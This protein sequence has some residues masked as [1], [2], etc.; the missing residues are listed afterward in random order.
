M[1]IKSKPGKEQT[2]ERVLRSRLLRDIR[3]LFMI[4]NDQLSRWLEEG[5]SRHNCFA[6]FFLLCFYHSCAPHMAINRCWLCLLSKAGIP[7]HHSSLTSYWAAE[8][9]ICCLCWA[10]GT[11]C[12]QVAVN[13]AIKESPGIWRT[14]MRLMCFDHSVSSGRLFLWSWCWNVA[15]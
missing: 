3:L 8:T 12:W 11:H 6:L 14:M 13:L 5:A 9:G 10:G 2:D 7:P 1:Q 15:R 4:S